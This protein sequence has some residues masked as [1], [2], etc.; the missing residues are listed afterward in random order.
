[1]TDWIEH[2]DPLECGVRLPRA[3]INL[4]LKPRVIE[5]WKSGA[6]LRECAKAHGVS[7]DTVRLWVSG[8]RSDAKQ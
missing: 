7:H 1:M 2:E 8:Y 6:T 4:W 5:Q 3:S